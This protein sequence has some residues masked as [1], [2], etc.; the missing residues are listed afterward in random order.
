MSILDGITPATVH[1]L[2]RGAVERIYGPPGTGKS[3]RLKAI[4]R[5]VVAT[6]GPESVLVT[7]F[8]VTAAKSIA[9][10]GLNLPDRQVGTLHAMAYR[11]VGSFLDVAQEPKVLAGWNSRALQHWYIKPDARRSNPNADGGGEAPAG[12]GGEA[13]LSAY[14]MARASFTP[15]ADM[16]HAVRQFATAWEAWKR[17][18]EAVDFT[19]MIQIALERA[20]DG[21]PAPGSPRVLISDE[22]QDMTL[23]E[24]ALVLAWGRHADRTIIA[25][26]DDQA[27]MNWRGGDCSAILALG[28]GPDGGPQPGVEIT[29]ILLDQSWR[30]PAAVHM[31]AQSWIELCSVRRDKDYRSRPEDGYAYAVDATIDSMKTAEQI[32]KQVHR[33]RSVMALASC[34]YMLRIL[35]K[36]LRTLGVPYANAYRPAESRWNPLRSDKGTT[37]AQRLFHYLISDDRALGGFADGPHATPGGKARLWTGVD[38][39]AWIELV[40]AEGV[41]AKGVKSRLKDNLPDGELSIAQSEGLFSAALSEADLDRALGPDLSWFM[42]VALP[43]MAEKLQYPEAIVRGFGPAALVD[44]PLCTVGTIHSVK[45]GEADVVYLSP[46]LSPAG[47]GEWST[48]GRPRDSVIRLLYVAMTRAR[49]ASVVLAPP[50]RYAVPRSTLIPKEMQVR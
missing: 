43:S 19:D 20:L 44:P 10:M 38:V 17:E 25:L 50:N 40:R 35:I 41:L 42:S 24:T 11:A 31:V 22:A 3:T 32:A 48:Y 30:I 39:R 23:L 9:K 7:S 8:T 14:D 16:P 13:L 26:D 5:E 36:N 15:L 4:I 28:T 29:D 37:P 47:Y 27:I 6:H 49:R 1:L 12:E 34:E 18:V 2:A 33:G 46:A 21:E 45:G